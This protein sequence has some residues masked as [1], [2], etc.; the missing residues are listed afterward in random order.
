MG[1]ARVALFLSSL[2]FGRGKGLDHQRMNF[3][4]DPFAQRCV[5]HLV[6]RKTALAFEGRAY[7]DRLVMALP[8]GDNGGAGLA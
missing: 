8:I 5:D 2:P 1:K 7:D 6:P 4:P 3:P